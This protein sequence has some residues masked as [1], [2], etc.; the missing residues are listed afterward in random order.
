MG[1]FNENGIQFT[2]GNA[3]IYTGGMKIARLAY[4]KDTNDNILSP[5][6]VINAIDIDWNSA[7]IP[8]MTTPITNTSQILKI[9][10]DLYNGS[11]GGGQ[12]DCPKF[13][14]IDAEDYAALE[15]YEQDAIYFVLGDAVSSD[16]EEE[17]NDDLD[18]DTLTTN[19]YVNDEPHTEST[20]LLSNSQT[21]RL[22]GTLRGTIIIEIP[23]NVIPEEYTTLILDGV[24]IVSDDNF[25]IEYKIQEGAKKQK[26][27]NIIIEKNSFN[28]IVC[29]KSEENSDNQ[30]G[31]IYSMN[32][33]NI[34]GAGYLAIQNK[35]GHG[36][37]G[38]ETS[39]SNLHLWCDATHDGV[40]GKNIK[41]IGGT[42]YFEKC[43]DAFG[44]ADNPS[45]SESGHIL[46]YDGQIKCHTLNGKLLDSKKIGIYFNEDLLTQQELLLCTNMNVLSQSSYNRYMGNSAD[47]TGNIIM[48][49]NRE[50][51]KT[52]SNGT[53]LNLQQITESI[54][55]GEGVSAITMDAY[56]V[57]YPYIQIN[58]Y[59]DKPIYFTPE[60]FGV[61]N[62]SVKLN[63]AYLTHSNHLHTVLYGA[64]T[65]NIHLFSVQDTLNVLE[66][67]YIDEN[68]VQLECDAVKSENN[69]EVESKDG[70]ILFVTSV[71]TDG[72][73]GGEVRITDSKGTIIISGCGQRGIKGN[74]IVIG[75]NA[76]ISKSSI[77]S[78]YTDP[79]DT[80]H[81]TT[82]DGLIYVKNNCKVCAACNLTGS[83]YDKHN[84]SG[85][86]DIFGRNGKS[87]SKGVFGTTNNELN[88]YLITGSIGAIL[89]LNL[90]NAEHLYYNRTFTSENHST[91]ITN[92]PGVAN[93]SAFAYDLNHYQ[94]HE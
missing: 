66:N 56:V 47:A 60:V 36:I 4:S 29:L 13:I 71:S 48:Y 28:R 21:Y 73:D 44:T 6:K 34:Y 70:S 67:T 80:T 50:D 49:M 92:D 38:K 75:P 27:L 37:R 74:A 19:L 53:L 17:E 3:G 15:T 20:I 22:T 58:G 81:Y 51:Y 14:T 35:G 65:G 10:G 88:G 40:H 39:I 84:E 79:T 9:L 68:K 55:Y 31:A 83:T 8:G 45:D 77:S 89:R 41:I 1:N 30:P 64:S 72:L 91:I 26:G 78:Y 61:N 62:A 69:I 12:C 32:N 90:G 23:A 76:V 85:F 42:Y 82:F 52:M 86:A 43:N 7:Q 18:I 87:A 93:E 11:A 33:L 5:Q 63:N 16:E 2:V 46:Y 25:G 57:K 54:T 24:T 94:I 59:L